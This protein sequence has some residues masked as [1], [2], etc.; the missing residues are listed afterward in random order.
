MK[1]DIKH[2][3]LG[4]ITNPYRMLQL[5]WITLEYPNYEWDVVIRYMDGD[6]ITVHQM[7]EYCRK[8]G[9]FRRVIEIN[10]SGI[11]GK[12]S[13]K[14]KLFFGLF[15]YLITFRK[16]KFFKQ[17][18]IKYA[19]SD[20]YGILC[21]ENS[22][23]FLG[24]S[25]MN[26]GKE[27]TVFVLE[28][29]MCDYA[30]Y[31]RMPHDLT[32]LIGLV[33]FKLGVVNFISKEYFTMNKYCIKRAFNPDLIWEKNY[34]DIVKL[35]DDDKLN[36]DYQNILKNTFTIVDFDYDVVVFTDLTYS[37][38]ENTDNEIFIEWIKN[39]YSGK[40]ILIKKHPR[41]TY[42]YDFSDM[43]VDYKYKTIPGEIILSLITNEI[44]IFQGPSTLLMHVRKTQEIISTHFLSIKMKSD[45]A[46][47]Y[48][49]GIKYCNTDMMHV[50]EL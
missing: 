49:E 16:K 14:I 28:D 1:E 21:A 24:S 33:L 39:T 13:T 43:N 6:P 5:I 8:S 36:V 42:E 17:T 12:I 38:K 41:D 29:G 19:G 47:N 48:H 23:S 45:Y 37:E 46:Q 40:K 3:A 4:E 25:M 30:G 7:A 44:V 27:K 22:L 15:I 50:V 34:K 35:F 20:D 9:C 31:S 32:Y 18:I 10:A 11:D 2:R 26:L